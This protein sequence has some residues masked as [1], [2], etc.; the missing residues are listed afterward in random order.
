LALQLLVIG[1]LTVER[2]REPARLAPVL[3]L[4]GLRMT[5]VGAAAGRVAHVTDPRRAVLP[6][7]DRLE[8]VSVVETK[9]L[10]HR[11]Q[12]LVGAE[13]G[14]AFGIEAR[15]PCSELSPVLHVEKHPGDEAGDAV[16]LVADRGERRD[17]RPVGVVN[18]RHAALMVEF[19]HRLDVPEG[20][21]P[22]RVA[23]GW[24]KKRE[25]A[26]LAEARTHSA[27]QSLNSLYA[28]CE[29]LL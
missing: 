11:A 16:A 2:K 7:H 22:P 19:A 20:P 26:P 6:V 23:R 28:P 10:G 3:A 18:S 15:H 12:L 25:S 27:R 5:P 24:I 17:L 13:Q 4:E 1:E 9:R 14:L 29:A 8:V 21:A